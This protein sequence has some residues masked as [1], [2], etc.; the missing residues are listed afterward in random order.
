[1][2]VGAMSLR[3]RRVGGLYVAE[4]SP[5]ESRIDWVTPTP[6]EEKELY[7]K[8]IE[9]GCHPRDLWDAFEEADEGF[10]GPPF[11]QRHEKTGSK[12]P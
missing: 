11:S 10:A 1:M 8:L 2:E 7:D 3:I 12:D 4:V 5:P 6:M 9:L